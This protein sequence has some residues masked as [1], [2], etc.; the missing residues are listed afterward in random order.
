[1]TADLRSATD[2]LRAF[3]ENPRMDEAM[4]E[5]ERLAGVL[6]DTIDDF[7]SA[8]GLE[9]LQETA[10]ALTNMAQG[11]SEALQALRGWV[12]YLR[13]KSNAFDDTLRPLGEDPSELFFGKEP[14]RPPD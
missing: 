3:E 10:L 1:M 9:P 4:A 14:R 8:D 6:Q 13:R 5:A 2:E 7:R 12:S 11:L